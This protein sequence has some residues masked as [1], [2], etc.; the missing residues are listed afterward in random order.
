M[1]EQ[2]VS[3]Q[4]VTDQG[5]TGRPRI[6]VIKLGALGD[7]ILSYRAMTAIRARHR[8]AHL[9]LLTIPSLEGLARAT[10]LFDEIWLDDRPRLSNV[11]GWWRLQ[12]RLNHPRFER[13]YDLQTSDRTRFYFRLMG[14]PFA[15][16]PEWV[17]HVRGCSHPHDNPARNSMH[18]LERQAEQLAAA[19]IERSDYPTVDFSWVRADVSHHHLAEDGAPYVLLV[20]GGSAAHPEKRWPAARYGELARR[21]VSIG[22]R[23][24][25]VGAGADRAACATVAAA[26]PEAVN[27]CDASPILELMALARDAAGAVGNDT[28]PMHLIGAMGCPVLVLYSGA[29]DPALTRPRGP[30]E[31]PGAARPPNGVGGGRTVSVLRRQKLDAVTV[32]EVRAAMRLRGK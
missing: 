30:Y 13:V 14:P 28:G 2:G 32:D 11:V 9:T 15:R 12:R 3:E 10:G 8:D 18:T 25:V 26:A 19:G 27:L 20:P 16:R 21:L 7:F 1:S 31:G 23:P 29:T 17:G 4:T 6:L 5:A 24:V 22:Y